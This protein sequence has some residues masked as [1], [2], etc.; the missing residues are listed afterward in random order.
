MDS[1][2]QSYIE[3]H[4]EAEPSWLSDLYRR[5]WQTRLYPRMCTDHIQGRILKMLVQLA[6]P[7][8]VLELGTFSGYSA[9]C[10]AEGLPQH[11]TV[12]TIEVDDE[13][14]TPIRQAFAESPYAD[15]ITLHIGDALKVLPDIKN[16]EKWDFLFIDADKR[17]YL[18]YLQT[19]LPRLTNDAVIVADNTL[20][21]GKVADEQAVDAQTQG[22][23]RFNDYVT[24]TPGFSPVILPVRDGLT[25]IKRTL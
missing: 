1:D 17:R 20:W 13:A 14:E 3:G 4:I 10:L 22:L 6:A 5:T 2:L 11:G 9:L 18:E 16:P 8:H 24:S 23:R 15:R 25:I 12:D 19:A 7:R 21:A